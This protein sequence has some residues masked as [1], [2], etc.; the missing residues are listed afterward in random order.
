MIVLVQILCMGQTW[1]AYQVDALKCLKLPPLYIDV[2]QAMALRCCHFEH[3]EG[4]C[5]QGFRMDTPC[6]TPLDVEVTKRTD[7]AGAWGPLGLSNFRETLMLLIGISSSWPVLQML[8]GCLKEAEYDPCCGHCLVP[9]EAYFLRNSNS[10]RRFKNSCVSSFGTFTGTRPKLVHMLAVHVIPV[11]QTS[12]KIHW[13][14]LS[15]I[16]TAHGGWEIKAVD[17]EIRHAWVCLL[18]SL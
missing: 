5:G 14:P 16:L 12:H 3:R 10:S 9:G 11:L 7:L 13:T 1:P 8:L 17:F 2:R 18:Y 4:R 6:D 15:R